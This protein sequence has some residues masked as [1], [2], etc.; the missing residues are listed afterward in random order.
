[1]EK[2]KSFTTEQKEDKYRILVVSSEPD[3]QK[4]FHTFSLCCQG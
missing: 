1:M 3:N 2:F 4:L